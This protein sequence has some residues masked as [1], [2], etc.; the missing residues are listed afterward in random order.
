MN[1]TR[2]EAKLCVNQGWAKLIDKIYDILPDETYVLQIKEKWGGLVF[3]VGSANED[4]HDFISN[5]ERESYTIC[6]EC[7]KPGELRGDLSWKLTLCDEHYNEIRLRN[8]TAR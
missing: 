5:V 6:E 7:G 8:Q 1:I 2:E 4:I 3:D